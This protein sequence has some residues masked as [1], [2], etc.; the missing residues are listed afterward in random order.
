MFSYKIKF[1]S[2]STFLVFT[3]KVYVYVIRVFYIEHLKGLTNFH[4]TA[5]K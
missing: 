1:C 4:E 5:F 3:T 2:S